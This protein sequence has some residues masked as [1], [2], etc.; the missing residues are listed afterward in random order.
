MEGGYEAL[1][2]NENNL[3]TEGSRTNIFFLKEETLITA[4]E[5]VI[6]NGIT[7]KHI[8]EICA[9][10]KIKVVFACVDADNIKEYEAVFMTGTSPIVLPFCCIDNQIFNVKIQLIERLRK[11]Y[12]KKAEESINL[13]RFK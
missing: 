4:P 10:N 6:L 1:L 8:L 3:I 2:V 5:N 9:E 7:R 12:L 11:L 13:F